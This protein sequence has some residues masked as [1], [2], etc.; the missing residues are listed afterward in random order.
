MLQFQG[1]QDLL[2]LR[3]AFQPQQQ[4]G[5]LREHQPQ[6]LPAP[7]VGGEPRQPGRDL[8]AGETG[9]IITAITAVTVL[10]ILQRPVPAVL[11]ALAS[12]ACLLLVRGRAGR[13]LAA[14]TTGSRG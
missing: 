5:V 11:T 7:R 10:A 4:S 2:A 8:G 14:L 1:R 9:V 13:L 3:A 6:P 12:V